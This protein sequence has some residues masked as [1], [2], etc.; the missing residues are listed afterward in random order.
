MVAP[1][2]NAGSITQNGMEVSNAMIGFAA[3]DFAS[4]VVV[5]A[6]LTLTQMKL[7]SP[8]PCRNKV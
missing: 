3:V 8:K 4:L 5:H 1:N 7:Q 6:G 2:A